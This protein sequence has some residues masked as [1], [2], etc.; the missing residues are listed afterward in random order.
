MFTKAPRLNSR[1]VILL[2]GFTFCMGGCTRHRDACPAA[3]AQTPVIL[4]SVPHDSSAFTQGLIIDGDAWIES[5][6]LY[7]E[8][9][10]RIVERA[11]GNIIQQKQ[12]PSN[13]FGEG[14]ALFS[15]RVFQ[16]TWKAGICFVY[17]RNTL[18]LTNHFRYEG[19]GW[20]LTNCDQW[21]Y[22]SDGSDIITVRSPE[23]FKAI[24]TIKVKTGNKAVSNLNELEWID[25]EIWANIFHSEQIVS[26]NPKTGCVTTIID[27]KTLPLEE[28]LHPEQD[29]L[30]GIAYD[31][32]NKSVWVTG[33]KWARIY[34]IDL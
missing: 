32:E 16:L 34:R 30:N 28:D 25:G 13:L 29:V 4:E 21:L 31:T 10:I 7:G 33:K 17:D 20:G 19:E 1:A 22:M 15:N 23:T 18:E 27:L 14:V 9:S 24:R 3:Q 11:T 12:L 2:A 5:T 8:S 6:G 26:I